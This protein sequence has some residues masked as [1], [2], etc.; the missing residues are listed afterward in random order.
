MYLYKIYINVLLDLHNLTL[1]LQPPPPLD[2]FRNKSA[3]RIGLAARFHEFFP[4]RFAH[5]VRPNL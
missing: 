2:I 5:I 1:I 3:A 4:Y